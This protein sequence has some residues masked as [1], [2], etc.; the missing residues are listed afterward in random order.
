MVEIINGLTTVDEYTMWIALGCVAFAFILIKEMLDSTMMAVA[1]S[2]ILLVGALA[3][4]YIF[5]IKFIIAAQDKDSN[6]L[7]ASAVGVICTL[8]LL[9]IGM[10][11]GM[12]M[13]EHRSKK[14]KL[15]RL[16][17]APPTAN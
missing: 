3:A 16:P 14:R 11:V 1:F 15:M 5:R 10:W 2:P 8:I 7:V 6:I 13:S 9:L 4:N 12:L 17:G